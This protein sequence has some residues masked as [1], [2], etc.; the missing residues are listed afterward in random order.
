MFRE[1]QMLSKKN[2]ETIFWCYVLYCIGSQI[3]DNYRNDETIE[4]I[5]DDPLTKLFFGF[6]ILYNIDKFE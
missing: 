5:H 3:I 1:T 2:R 6:W 4:K